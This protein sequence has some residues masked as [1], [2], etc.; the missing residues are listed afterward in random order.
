MRQSFMQKELTNQKDWYEVDT[1]EGIM[2]IPYDIV[3]H[4][5]ATE[6]EIKAFLPS[7]VKKIY[8]VE[9]RNGFGAR[10]SAKGFKDVADWQVFDTTEEANQFLDDQLDLENDNTYG[11]VYGDEE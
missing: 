3:G 1:N 11:D 4:D 8:S 5:D 7:S 10:L 6:E 9:K 2:C